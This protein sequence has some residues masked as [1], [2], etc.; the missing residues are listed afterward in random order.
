M[1]VLTAE[2]VKRLPVGTDV[3][4]VNDTTGE[5][6]KLWILRCGRR[7]MLKG[8]VTPV[9]MMIK[10]MDGMHYEEVET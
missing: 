2:Q 7:K 4:V 9:P 6:G 8:P 5:R 3:Y 1:K 10:D